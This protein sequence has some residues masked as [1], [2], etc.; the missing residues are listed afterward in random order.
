MV[1]PGFARVI[2]LLAALGGTQHAVA[3]PAAVAA[4]SPS[5]LR[6]TMRMEDSGELTIDG[7]RLSV[8]HKDEAWAPALQRD[9]KPDSGY[10]RIT[11]SLCQLQGTFTTGSG[12][13][14]LAQVI[15]QV[16]ADTVRYSVQ[17]HGRP[18][19]STRML[20]L[21]MIL[22]VADY[23]GQSV[24]FDDGKTELPWWPQEEH[25][26]AR[27]G[28]RMLRIPL[29]SG[30]TLAIR[31]TFD[32]S[33][34]DIRVWNSETY[35]LHMGF[36]PS[37]GMLKEAKIELL[38]SRLPA[39]D[40]LAVVYNAHAKRP[41]RERIAPAKAATFEPDLALMAA[42]RGGV[43]PLAALRPR[44][45]ELA[46][47]DGRPVRLWGVNFTSFY[48]PHELADKTV[49]HLD[50][51]GFNLVRQT[52]LLR[53]S[54]DWNPPECFSLLAFEQDSR[55]LNP[56][57]WDRF[58]YLNAKLRQKGIR[59]QLSVHSWRG[60]AAGD[61]A[62]LHVSDEDDAAWADAMDEMNHWFWRKR[63]DPDNM[64][65]VFDERC[66]RVD[67]EFARNLLA[68]VNP[69]TGI[70]YGQDPQVLTLELINEF[71]SEY[72]ILCG[73]VFP[74]YWHKKLAALLDA[75]ARSRGVEPF[76]LYQPRMGRQQQCRSEFLNAL[77][78]AYAKRMTAVV[79]GLG[80]EGPVEFQ[81]LWK[82]G[83]ADLRKRRRTD[84]VIEDHAYEDPLA[85]QEPDHFAYYLTKSRL[86]QRPL[87]VGEFC[88]TENP[89]LQ[90]ARRPARSML[91]AAITAY[92]SLQNFAG[93]SWF[94]WSD[95]LHRVAPDGWAAA[96]ASARDADIIAGDAVFL[97]HMRTAGTIFKNRYLAASVQPATIVT[98]P[99]YFPADYAQMVDGQFPYKPGWQ[100]VHAFR[101]TFGPV[102]PEQYRAA[103]FLGTPPNPAVSDT[104]QIVKDTQRKQLTFS[105]PQAEGLSGYLD[106]RPM[107][108][109]A[110]LEV[111]GQAG[112]ATVMAVTL[113]GAVLVKSKRLLLSR[114]YTDATGKEFAEGGASGGQVSLKGVLPGRWTMRTT[115]PFAPAAPLAKIESV[116]GGLLRLPS[117]EW[118]ECELELQF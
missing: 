96:K 89:A 85:A 112:F 83:D 53:E 54:R 93:V 98:D 87:I 10:P 49:E 24:A 62:I 70:A 17:L 55:G 37:A 84:D 5:S 110:V 77:D 116:P 82:G 1:L 64:L 26:A 2:T 35:E 94:C 108:G 59:L 41:A 56:L 28:V 38:L 61:V 66:F 43:K 21:A 45:E 14:A 91:C 99:S 97:D 25:L 50:R 68:H 31:G 92:G 6:S 15:G 100:S 44:G 9:L 42:M 95:G 60:Y 105:A 73:N 90:A 27:P 86:A 4:A 76:D 63:L 20:C 18:G 74:D 22:P 57:A 67:A 88:Q 75:F 69:Y 111:A 72:T 109:L 7:L 40:P 104:G 115:R 46:G 106:G 80:Y 113:D 33:L 81:S 11:A 47:P 29:K 78:E 36:N 16:D 103:W 101:K 48:P 52:Q 30:G 12:V 71:S 19:K 3:A 39:S 118:N 102:P 65:P 32:V 34:H 114:T 79:R 23:R 51:L 58:D 107:T 8:V 117:V 13:Y